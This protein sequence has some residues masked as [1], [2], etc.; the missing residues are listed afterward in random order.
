VATEILVGW[1]PIL[2]GVELKTGSKG[3][4]KVFV[5][6]DKVFDKGDTG[7]MPKAGELTRILQGRLGAPLQWRQD[8]H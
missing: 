5:G 7:R 6:G 8:G 2:T 4:F 3:V 1:A